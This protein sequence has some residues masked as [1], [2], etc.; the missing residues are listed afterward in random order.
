MLLDDEYWNVHSDLTKFNYNELS[1]GEMLKF[2][3]LT[4]GK[5]IE[6]LYW[7]NTVDNTNPYSSGF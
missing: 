5:Q 7:V 4:T 1:N 3:S 2:M 6:N